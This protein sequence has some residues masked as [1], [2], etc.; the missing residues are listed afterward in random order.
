MG[1]RSDPGHWSGALATDDAQLRNVGIRWGT[2][3]VTPWCR[4]SVLKTLAGKS[5]A[6]MTVLAQTGVDYS[7]FQAL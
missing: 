3:E 6:A 5:G 4:L 1:K 2:G 7:G